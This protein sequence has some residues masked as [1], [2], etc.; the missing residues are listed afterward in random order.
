MARV[1]VEDCVVVCPSRFGL[2]IFTTQRARESGAGAGATIRKSGDKAPVIAIREIA[3]HSIVVE[4]LKDALIKRHRA[5]QA[6]ERP[7][8]DDR[9][10]SSVLVETTGPSRGWQTDRLHSAP[11]HDPFC[12]PSGRAG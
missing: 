2:I 3:D 10:D 8:K 5:I 11:R 4:A 9:F 7:P 1:T 12:D 6:A